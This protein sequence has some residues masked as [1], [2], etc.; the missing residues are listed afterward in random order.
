MVHGSVIRISLFPYYFTATELIHH[1]HLS[2]GYQPFFVD[3]Y[4]SLLCTQHLSLY[5]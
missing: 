1:F 2:P 4:P 3:F 5:R